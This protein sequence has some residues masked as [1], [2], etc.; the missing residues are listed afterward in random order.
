[1]WHETPMANM[2]DPYRARCKKVR[3]DNI[4][5]GP[6]VS[7]LDEGGAIWTPGIILPYA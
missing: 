3:S 7:S 6:G 4:A 1:M 5:A 2:G